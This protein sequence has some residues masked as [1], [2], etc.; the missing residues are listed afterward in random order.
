MEI[1][2]AISR[3]GHDKDSIYVIVKEEANMV[4]LADGNLKP[5]EKPKKKNRKHIQIIKKLPK[6]ITQVF[7]QENFRNEEI[8]RAIKLYR[9][10]I[11]DTRQV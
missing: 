11:M 8:K 7:T 1:K 6:E 2:L 10:S 9:K 4:Y 3:S 5:L